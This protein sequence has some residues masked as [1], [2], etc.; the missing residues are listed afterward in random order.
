MTNRL[1]DPGIG[2]PADQN[3]FRTDRLESLAFRPHD[4]GRTAAGVVQRFRAAGWHGAVVGPHGSGKSTLLKRLI[5][6]AAADG[7]PVAEVFVN[8]QTPRRV[9][10]AEAARVVEA[11]RG[12]RADP[13]TP[14][15]VIACDGWC[16]LPPWER[17]RLRR[18]A[19]AAGAGVL[20][21]AHLSGWGLPVLYRTR[22]TPALLAS[23]VE[24]LQPHP[25]V[26]AQA[27]LRA[28]WSASRGNIRDA[29]FRLYDRSAAGA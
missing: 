22:T 21:L 17:R 2:L 4:P 20:G 6:D 9:R 3:P 18:A 26:A 25:H 7:H 16:H 19:R 13:G 12:H 1:P 15:V 23:L 8:R 29:L 14:G 5:A 24:E 28:A 11:L 27:G 10:R